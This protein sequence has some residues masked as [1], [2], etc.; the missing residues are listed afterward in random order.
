MSNGARHGLGAVVGLIATPVLAGTLMLGLERAVRYA[1]TFE[2]MSLERTAGLAL[3]VAAAALV[4]LLAGSRLSPLA[5]LIPG[6]AFSLHGLAWLLSPTI[7]LDIFGDLL[8]GP[9]NRGYLLLEPQ[10]VGT[11]LGVALLV[12]SF[13]PSRWRSGR[14]GP[15][16][17][18]PPHAAMASQ[19]AVPPLADPGR[20][21]RPERPA[22]PFGPPPAGPPRSGPGQDTPPHPPHRAARH[23]DDDDEGPG[24]WT[25]IYGGR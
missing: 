2:L 24:E 19:G 21:D 9:L 8:P 13:P 1:R 18:V 14:T 11:L 17:A 15:P 3:L 6:A 4:G 12:A 25:R 23:D 10:G 16:P 20:P 7:M 5:S 22:M